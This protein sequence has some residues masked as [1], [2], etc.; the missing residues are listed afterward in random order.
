MSVNDNLAEV[1]ARRQEFS[2]DPKKVAFPLKGQ[3][4]VG[5]NPGMSKEEISARERVLQIS[6]EAKMRLWQCGVKSRLQFGNL[7][8]I[9]EGFG[10]YSVG[11]QG[12]DAAQTQPLIE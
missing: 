10:K 12:F 11:Y 2:P 1:P 8:P 3:V 7:L 4:D 5:F 9:D 6:K